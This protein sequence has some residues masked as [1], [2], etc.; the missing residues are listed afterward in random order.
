MQ[1]DDRK[2]SPLASIPFVTRIQ[3][4]PSPVLSNIHFN[5]TLPST[6]GHV[7]RAPLH[8]N[9]QY[10]LPIQVLHVPATS[11]VMAT[12]MFPGYETNSGGPPHTIL[13]I[14]PLFPLS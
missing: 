11:S 3:S 12:V 9:L 2:S 6:A 10:L 4:K 14:L 13:S 5:V 8:M 7:F 1:T